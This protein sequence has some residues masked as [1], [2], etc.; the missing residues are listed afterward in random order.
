MSLLQFIGVINAVTCIASITVVIQWWSGTGG[1][2]YKHNVGRSLMF[3]MAMLTIVSA[4]LALL[5]LFPYRRIYL[6]ALSI[7]TL[8]LMVSVVMFGYSRFAIQR[9]TERN[10]N[11]KESK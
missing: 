10:L 3:L 9:Q 5:G 8:M 6:L 7:T 1:K 2:W 4:N 11:K